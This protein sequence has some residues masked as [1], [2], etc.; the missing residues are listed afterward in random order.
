MRK[1]QWDT[2]QTVSPQS[3][4]FV[5][6]LRLSHP[7]PGLLV[8]EEGVEPVEAVLGELILKMLLHEVGQES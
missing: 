1:A 5:G 7:P 8:W 2:L 4:L 3:L 6:Q